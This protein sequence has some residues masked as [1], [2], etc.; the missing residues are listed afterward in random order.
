MDLNIRASEVPHWY[1]LYTKP[2]SEF[3]ASAQLDGIEVVNYLP[4][5][6]SLKN[7]SDRKKKVIEPVLKG[8]VFIYA[9]EKHRLLALE[10]SAII[11]CISDKGRPARIPEWQIENLKILLNHG[12]KV[13][14]Q[15]GIFPG[16]TVQILE[17]PLK[18][19]IGKIISGENEKMIAVSIDLLNRSVVTHLPADSRLKIVNRSSS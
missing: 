5:L 12:S 16:D 11:R 8:Y 14:V 3:K 10:Q 4:V 7:W 19:I 1:A 9:D 17:G 18:G 15:E 13:A 6:E 2:R